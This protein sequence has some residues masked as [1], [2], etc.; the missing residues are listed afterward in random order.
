M[1]FP[2]TLSTF[3][4]PNPT[5]RLNSP[6]QSSIVGTLSSVL[7]Q[8]EAVIGVDGTNSVVGTM[9]Y[10]LRSSASEGGGHVQG[11][12][13]GGTG[14]TTYSKGNI[15]VATSASVLAKLSVGNDGQ[16]LAAD[17]S[18]ASGVK[19]ANTTTNKIYT[20][21]S[22]IQIRSATETSI[23]STSL[24]GSTLGTNNAVKTTTHL[25]AWQ[26][27]TYGSVLTSFQYGGQTVAS[28]MLVPTSGSTTSTVGVVT[29][30]M[31]ANAATDQQRHF[32]NLSYKMWS[33]DTGWGINPAFNLF[34][35]FVSNVGSVFSIDVSTNT[36]SSINSS[37]N[38]T[39]GMTVRTFKSDTMDFGG[40]VVEKIV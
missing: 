22:V 4:L 39:Y 40:T 18:T 15:L 23:F 6:S 32:L 3:T 11:V 27:N 35:P 5:Q 29:H 25:S 33:A 28:V 21:A 13:F 20:N 24:T 12:A 26:L 38:Q 19:W 30:T 34:T 16:V 31:I 7:G 8:V 10:H 1:P 2:S 36:T 14:Q 37:A 9:M 17:S